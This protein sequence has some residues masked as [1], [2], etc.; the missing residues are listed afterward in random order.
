[1]TWRTIANRFTLNKYNHITHHVLQLGGTNTKM[2]KHE[3]SKYSAESTD[4][5]QMIGHRDVT[6]IITFG[7]SSWVFTGLT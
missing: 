5:Q 7:K 6:I 3:I 2:A 4:M 1:M